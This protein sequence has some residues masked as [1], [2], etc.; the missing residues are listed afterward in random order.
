M[1]PKLTLIDGLPRSRFCRITREGLVEI[2]DEPRS[3]PYQLAAHEL[4]D[5]SA[6]A[7][8]VSHL[9]LKNWFTPAVLADFTLFVCLLKHG[10]PREWAGWVQASR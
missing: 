3:Y 8:W 2:R 9:T 4:D 1:I 5:M 6:F 10:A 7:R